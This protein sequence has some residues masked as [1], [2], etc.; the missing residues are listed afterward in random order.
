MAIQDRWG[1]IG[2]FED[3]YGSAATFSIADA[4]AG[5][6]Y[7]DVCLVAI[8]GQSEID[9]TVDESNGVISVNGAGGAAD[10]IAFI[11]TPM[12][13][14]RNGTMSM[15]AR[16]KNSSATDYRCFVGWQQT[17]SLSETVN[18]FTLSGTTLTANNGGEAVG[19]YFDSA[20]TTDDFRFMASS[21]GTADT[22]AAVF[23]HL[24]STKTTL[25]SLG[26][27][28]NATIAADKYSVAQVNID[29]NG[30]VEGFFG[31]ESMANTNGLTKIATLDSGTMS[32]TVLYFPVLIL[33]ASST[34]DPI[35]EV[36]Y[37]WCDGNRYWTA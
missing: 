20:A 14:D 35:G 28:C 32:A 21:A 22:T 17:A 23:N 7:K 13:P 34:G 25:G 30:R 29:P 36:D 31:D 24:T 4:T 33:V 37:F 15:G 8:S 16:F 26:I 12:R 5:T 27:R 19:F 6:R 11:G 9:F 3:F 10:G 18:P 1:R 2:F